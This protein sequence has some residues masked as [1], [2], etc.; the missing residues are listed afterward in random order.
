MIKLPTTFVPSL[1]TEPPPHSFPPP[2]LSRSYSTIPPSS[3]PSPPTQSVPPLPRFHQPFTTT[4]PPQFHHLSTTTK[5]FV[6]AFSHQD[7]SDDDN[8]DS[9]SESAFE[10]GQVSSW[11]RWIEKRESKISLWFWCIGI[12]FLLSSFLCYFWNQ[13]FRCQIKEDDKLNI[14]LQIC[15]EDFQ[16]SSLDNNTRAVKKSV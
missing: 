2:P 11:R 14:E 7:E 6:P 1:R 13:H 3:F 15:L 5:P 4:Q 10:D 12:S 9:D 16:S 8:D